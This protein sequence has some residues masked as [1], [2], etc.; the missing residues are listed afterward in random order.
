MFYLI[1]II[2]ALLS[3]GVGI[4]TVSRLRPMVE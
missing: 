2:I 3:V 4:F 1:W